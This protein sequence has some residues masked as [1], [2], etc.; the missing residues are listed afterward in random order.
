M[1]SESCLHK[2]P[3]RRT[4]D[5]KNFKT[6]KTSPW[7]LSPSCYTFIEEGLRERWQRRKDVQKS[8]KL[9]SVFQVGVWC[10]IIFIWAAPLLT[11]VTH[12]CLHPS[13]LQPK[14]TNMVFCLFFKVVKHDSNTM[15]MRNP[16]VLLT[17][18]LWCVLSGRP[19]RLPPWPPCRGEAVADDSRLGD[20][21]IMGEFGVEV[22]A[23]VSVRRCSSLCLCCC[24][25]WHTTTC[26]SWRKRGTFSVN[27]ERV[28][29]WEF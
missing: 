10:P 21:A 24:S 11:R 2:K 8:C 27:W 12:S 17:P 4:S 22:S 7:C 28:Y 3:R 6:W 18:G 20:W 15:F 16:A 19:N 13:L 25:I 9:T 14:N 1:L 23:P 29:I 26:C 5:I